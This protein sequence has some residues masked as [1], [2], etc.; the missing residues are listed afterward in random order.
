KVTDFGL[1]KA[2]DVNKLSMAGDIIGTPEYMSPEQILGETLDHRS[3]LFGLGIVLYELATG[4]SPFREKHLVAIARA[5]CE[6]EPPAPRSLR[7]DLPWWFEE[8]IQW[9]MRKKPEER[10]QSAAEVAT[11]LAEKS[12][13]SNGAER[14]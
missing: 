2:A 8:I 6:T 9:L 5:I 11:L 13:K 12:A 14:P 3:D 10:I 7:P 1:A 4:Q